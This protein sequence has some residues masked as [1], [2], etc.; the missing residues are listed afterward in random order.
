VCW[1]IQGALSSGAFQALVYDELHTQGDTD[2]YPRIMGLGEASSSAAQVVG[3]LVAAA[4]IPLGFGAILVA[5]SVACIVAGALMFSFPAAPPIG[6]TGDSRYLHLL[7]DGVR[8]VVRNRTT[9]GFVLFTGVVVGLGS[10]D[11]FYGLILRDSGLGNEGIS[12]WSAALFGAGIV[13]SLVAHRVARGG[14]RPMVAVTLAGAVA[15]IAASEVP[16]GVVPVT[17]I[18]AQGVLALQMVAFDARL[19][20]MITTGA[21]ATVT[22]VHGF[23]MELGAIAAFL[24]FGAVA[25]ASSSRTAAGVIGG[26]VLVVVAVAL[27]GWWIGLRRRRMSG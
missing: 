18:V 20:G 22:S 17:L 3:S 10:V 23:V 8:Q 6:T 2:R 13:G 11:E 9:L 12:L 19:Q 16:G 14:L 5:S 21:R 4:I 7:R 27:A 25:T 1:G 24:G 26:A 15:L